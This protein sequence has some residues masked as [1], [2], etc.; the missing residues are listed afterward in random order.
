MNERGGFY[1]EYGVS[2]FAADEFS[3]TQ[4]TGLHDSTKWEELTEDE[5]TKWT[6]AGNMPSEWKG[7]PIYEG[8]IVVAYDDAARDSSWGLDRHHTG[9]IEYESNNFS[10]NC[11]GIY[12]DC[13]INA[14][15]IEI[16][17]NIY[18]TPQLLEVKSWMI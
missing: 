6:L 8:D 10:L 5:R 17:G 4:F 12:L 7:K 16:I 18:E 11:N 15:N 2:E 9:F 3:L 1:Y 14:E 13:W